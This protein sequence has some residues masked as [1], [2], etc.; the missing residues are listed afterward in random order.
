MVGHRIRQALVGAEGTDRGIHVT[1]SVVLGGWQPDNAVVAQATGRFDPEEVVG[2]LRQLRTTPVRLEN[3]LRY[4]HAGGHACLECG[5]AGSA[6]GC[7]EERLLQICAG[8]IAHGERRRG[9]L[10]TSL[11]RKSWA[12]IGDV[13]PALV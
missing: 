12:T 13:Y 1:G 7:V 10:H 9:R 2:C 6:G 8:H 5:R 3:G 4:C 11:R